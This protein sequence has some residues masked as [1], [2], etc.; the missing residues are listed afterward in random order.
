M[1][2]L[3]VYVALSEFCKYDDRARRTLVEA[4]FEVKENPLGRR[5]RREE[6]L[7]TLQGADAVIA[8]V[9][10]YDGEL[11]SG[12]ANLRCVSRCGVG[13][14]AIDLEAAR[15]L[16]IAVFSTPDEVTEPVAQMT[17][18]MILAL[19]RNFPQHAAN[20]R[21][22]LWIKHAGHLLSEWNVGLIGFGRIGRKVGSYL[23][24]F[25]AQVFVYDPYVALSQPSSDTQ[26]IQFCPLPKLLSKSDLVSIHAARPRDDG[27]II[28]PVEFAS[29]K[30]GSRIVNTARSYL[31]DESALFEALTSGQLSAAALDVFDSEP[32]IGSLTRLP[33]VLCTPHVASLTKG[34]RIAMEVRCAENVAMFFTQ[35]SGLSKAKPIV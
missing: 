34:A 25:G 35:K 6:M 28:G 19:A 32:Y 20:S 13:T 31:V 29:M 1:P 14:D 4:G 8:G 15:R 2:G 5:L 7:E 11:L 17:V 24:V 9:E 26:N 22:G 21:S 27:P 33:Q 23:H 12:L 16:N 10:P 18:G 30:R 3:R